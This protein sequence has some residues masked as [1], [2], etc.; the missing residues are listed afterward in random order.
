MFTMFAA[1]AAASF[2]PDIWIDARKL[3]KYRMHGDRII[4]SKNS[5]GIYKDTL[6]QD[7]L[8]T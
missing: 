6:Y 3:T 7:K 8:R 5:I 2:H 1:I 4:S